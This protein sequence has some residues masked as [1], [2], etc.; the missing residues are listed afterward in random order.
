MFFYTYYLLLTTFSSAY[1]FGPLS[2]AKDPNIAMF[3]KPQ[4]DAKA[5]DTFLM[6]IPKHYS[7]SATNN[8]GSH[9]SQ[10]QKIATV[11]VQADS[12]NYVLFLLNNTSSKANFTHLVDSLRVNENYRVVYAINDFIAFKEN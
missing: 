2:F 3:T 4:K 8:I 12:A 7:V 9:V 11:P 5:I 1:S 10:R 6:T